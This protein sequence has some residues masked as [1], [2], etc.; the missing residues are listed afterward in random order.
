MNNFNVARR[1]VPLSKLVYMQKSHILIVRNVA[2]IPWYLLEKQ[3]P[4]RNRE[5]AV[6]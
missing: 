5:E 3:Q 4:Y 6:Y 1:Q 2:F